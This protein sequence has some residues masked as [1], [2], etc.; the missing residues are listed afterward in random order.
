MARKWLEIFCGHAARMCH[1]RGMKETQGRWLLG[2]EHTRGVLPGALTAQVGGTGRLVHGHGAL[3]VVCY[4]HYHISC[5]LNF[6]KFPVHIYLKYPQYCRRKE[7]VFGLHKCR[8]DLTVSLQCAS[9]QT[10]LE[11]AEK[12][13]FPM[14]CSAQYCNTSAAQPRPS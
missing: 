5:S 7:A 6:S 2:R 12:P 13:L 1:C 10:N 11:G 3:Q 14:R 8:K 9:V 4:P